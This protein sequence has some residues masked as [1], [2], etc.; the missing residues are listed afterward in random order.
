[1][2]EAGDIVTV[3]GYH[4]VAFF[5]DHVN[6]SEDKFKA[7]MVGDDKMFV[8]HKEEAIDI[9]EEDSVCSCGQVGCPW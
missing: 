1:M 6:N 5:V 4:G 9:L 3:D 8:F 7:H 2:I